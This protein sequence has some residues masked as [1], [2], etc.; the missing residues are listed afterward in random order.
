MALFCRIQLLAVALMMFMGVLATAHGA[1]PASVFVIRQTSKTPEAVVAAIEK[2][3]EKQDWLFL[4]ADTIKHGE[5]TL[6][7]VCLPEIGGLIWPQGLHMSALL[8]CGNV[9]IYRK[10]GKTEVSMLSGRYMHLLVLTPEMKKASDAAE[11]LLNAMLEAVL[12]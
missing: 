7:K 8:P 2:Y 11:P 10:D 1:E 5:I 12:K 9:S 6:V 4:G 3:A